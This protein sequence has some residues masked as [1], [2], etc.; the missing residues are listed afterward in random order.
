MPGENA[1]RR[2]LIGYALR[3]TLADVLIVSELINR[4]GILKA[5]AAIW[6]FR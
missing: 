1:E 6:G 5:A 3:A 2:Y 4:R